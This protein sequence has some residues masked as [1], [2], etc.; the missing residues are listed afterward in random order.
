MAFNEIKR[1]NTCGICEEITEE[2][3]I[4]NH[5]CLEGYKRY[6]TDGN[7]YFYPVCDNGLIMRRSAMDNGVESIVLD[8]PSSHPEKNTGEHGAVEE[9]SSVN[10]SSDSTELEE[11]LIE[12]VSKWE[13]LYNYNLPLIQRNRT[14]T[15]EAWKAVSEALQGRLSPKKAAKKWKILRDTYYR[16]LAEEKLPSGSG[17]PTTK[18][19]WKHFDQ[20]DFLRDVSL[21]KKT[22]SNL[23]NDEE[24]EENI[25]PI[26]K[27]NR[28]SNLSSEST[29][30]SVAINKIAD[31][32]TTMNAI[33]EPIKLPALPPLV[34]Q[35]EVDG[36]FLIMGTQI[37]KLPEKERNTLIFEMMSFFR[38]KISRLSHLL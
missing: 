19:K 6:F 3:L 37:R 30:S 21:R 32:I 28:S 29:E 12:E 11:L 36:L 31:A 16:K 15:G 26:P 18:R 9:P 33:S 35:D 24:N 5:K 13:A 25:P 7:R 14:I 38:E 34:K 4:S 8:E 20:L 2:S 10:N 27:K 22:T 23:S 17:R 1:V